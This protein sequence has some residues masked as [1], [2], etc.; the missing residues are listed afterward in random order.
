MATHDNKT[1]RRALLG[2]AV[3]A[4]AFLGTIAATAMA[5]AKA[6]QDGEII[7]AWERSQAAMRELCAE[8]WGTFSADDE[9]KRY[10]ALHEILSAEETAIQGAQP[11]TLKGVEVQLWVAFRHTNI[12]REDEAD[13]AHDRFAEIFA[14]VRDLDFEAQMIVR[15]IM[16]LRQ[17][18]A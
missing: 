11:T 9:D 14:T 1:S 15:A 7:A 12:S 13:L 8:D 10:H 3:A 16:A 5:E 6:A 4:P 18:G 17:M 2:A